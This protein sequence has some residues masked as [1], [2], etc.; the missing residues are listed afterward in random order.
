MRRSAEQITDMVDEVEQSTVS[1][2]TRMDSDRQLLRLDPFNSNTDVE[3]RELG[4]EFRSFTSNEPRTFFQKIVSLLSEAKLLIQV[5]YGMAQEEERYRYDLAERFYYGILESVNQRLRDRIE[6][7]LQDQ[8]A[9]L[10]PARGWGA[11]RVLL[12]NGEDGTSFPDIKIWDARNVHWQIGDRG[13]AWACYKSTRTAK[14]VQS[15]Y[16]DVDLNNYNEEDTIDIYDFYDSEHNTVVGDGLILKP[17]TEHGS[18]RTPVVLAPVGPVPRMWAENQNEGQDNDTESDFGE[19]IFAPNRGVYNSVNEIMSIYLE[20]ASKQLHQTYIHATDEEGDELEENPN[21][22]DAVITI[23]REDKFAPLQHIETTKDVALLAQTVTGMVQ[24]GAL[25]YTAYGE[26]SVAISG[27]AITQLNQ[28]HLT[29]VGPVAKTIQHLIKDALGLIVDQFLAGRFNPLTLRGF[30]NN[31]DYMQVTFTPEML[32]NLPPPIVDLNAEL[33]QD[34]VARMAMAQQARTGPTGPLL[35]DRYI[36]DSILKLPDAA[37][38]QRMIE[39]QQAKLASPAALSFSLARSS[40]MQGEEELAQLH[41]ADLQ[42][43]RMMQMLQL[44]QIQAAVQMGTPPPGGNGASPNGGG[45]GGQEAG[46]PGMSPTVMPFMQTAGTPAPG[47]RNAGP[48]R[49]EGAPRPGA[50]SPP[51][52][53]A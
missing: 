46:P 49:P 14:V 45:G 10:V 2:Q 13:L 53:G 22:S 44:M 20:L 31:R 50:Q 33:P 15:E 38:I 52:G 6:P 12:R 7:E 18:P 28:Q 43:Q 29:V 8:L 27:Y 19:S 5:P 1:R 34:D 26:L 21:S 47:P 9:G 40:A 3:G 25:P 17:P 32:Q 24:R 4:T 30:G 39:E 42:F 23:G 11:L 36:R 51:P 37:Q 48:N 35:P 41:L 16:P